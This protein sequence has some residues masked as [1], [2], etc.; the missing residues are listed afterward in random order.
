MIEEEQI[1]HVPEG[2]LLTALTSCRETPWPKNSWTR[3]WISTTVPLIFFLQSPVQQPVMAS[4]MFWNISF[5]LF[6]CSLLGAEQRV[7]STGG[8]RKQCNASQGN[9]CVVVFIERAY[10]YGQEH[11]ASFVHIAACSSYCI[12]SGNEDFL[13]SSLR[14]IWNHPVSSHLIRSCITDLLLTRTGTIEAHMN[15]IVFCFFLRFWLC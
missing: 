8:F 1:V 2:S 4:I 3:S 12:F 14:F 10:T 13:C 6:C 11:A 9:C 7:Q 5:P 15:L